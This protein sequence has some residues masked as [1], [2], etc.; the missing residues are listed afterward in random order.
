MLL[1][2]QELISIYNNTITLD[3]GH[4]PFELFSD[5]AVWNLD[6][7]TY[8]ALFRKP[9]PQGN[10]NTMIFS[11]GGHWTTSLFAG[12]HDSNVDG[13]GLANLILL[14]EKA[15]DKWLGQI[16]RTLDNV[17]SETSQ[18]KTPKKRALVRAYLPGH[19]GCHEV[20]T[21][22]NGPVRQ[23]NSSMSHSYNWGWIRK[24]NDVFKVSAIY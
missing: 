23:Y 17:N 19:D 6:P 4:S 3:G 18:R 21:L 15:M 1:N 9:L 20:S 11:T 22:L 8:L 2:K 5:E 16:I 14:F 10:Y 12:F 7:D 13:D 24:Y